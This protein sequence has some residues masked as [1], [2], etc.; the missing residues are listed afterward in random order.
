MS[1]FKGAALML[2]VLPRPAS[3]S[4]TRVTTRLVP[5]GARGA[6]DRRLH[7]FKVQPRNPIPHDVVFYKQRH[8]VENM[9]ESSRTGDAS[10]PDTTVAPTPTSRQSAS[11]QPSSS[12]SD[13]RVL[14]LVL[15]RQ[16]WGSTP[17][18]RVEETAIRN[19]AHDHG[20]NFSLFVPTT[21]PAFVPKWLPKPR[22]SYALDRFGPKGL[23]AV[24]EA[25]I[26]E[27]GGAGRVE[28]IS[29]R[30]A[31]FQRGDAFRTER[32]TFQRSPNGV[33]SFEEVA[34]LYMQ[35]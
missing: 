24:V 21:K 34:E 35:H 25:L 16:K 2:P 14:S 8:G 19:R 6:Q 15:C 33:G 22:L 4:P 3:C 31:R 5:A 7:P 11:P 12:G 23:A 18:T 29:A 9:L 17:F 32:A 28:S 1:D 26:E 30:A 27:H 10:T 20:Y 13:Q